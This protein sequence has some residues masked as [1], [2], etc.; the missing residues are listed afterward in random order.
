MFVKVLYQ[1]LFVMFCEELSHPHLFLYGKYGF[2]SKSQISLSST[3]YFNQHL[4]KYTHKFS[5]DSDYIFCTQ[6]YTKSKYSQLDKYWHEK[7]YIR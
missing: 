1:S 6:G 2:Q 4:L 5:S 7:S 3:K